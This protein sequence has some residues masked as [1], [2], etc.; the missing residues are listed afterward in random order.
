M[1]QYAGYFFIFVA[2]LCWGFLGILGRIAMEA[3]LAPL[4]VAFWRA[5][6]GGAFLFMHAVCIKQA[7]VHESKDLVFFCLFG[8]LA[9]ATFF[10]VYQ[11]AV[12]EGGAALASVLLYT[13]PAWVAIFSRIFFGLRFTL[14]TCVAIVIAL[15]GCLLI[16]ISPIEPNSAENTAIIVAE[17]VA[18]V[19]SENTTV[20]ETETTA[21]GYMAFVGIFFGLLSGFLYATHYVVTKKFL[22]SYTPFTLY[23]YSMLAAAVCLF[24]FANIRVDLGLTA[25]LAILGIGFV[26]TYVAYWTYCESIRRLHPTKV[27]VLATLE[28]VVATVAAWAIWGENF[29]ALGWFGAVLILLTVVIFL[30]DD[31]RRLTK[32]NS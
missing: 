24:P 14:I 31:K 1:A 4:D 9:I 8:V 25:W 12:K 26:S 32:D 17:S 20:G 30:V 7:K 11:Y 6:I 22:S 13:A 5:L 18:G 21:T 2:A 3:G 27:A 15:V 23:G 28:P 29:S 16:S 19:V 10:G